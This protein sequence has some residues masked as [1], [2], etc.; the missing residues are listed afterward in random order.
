M[1]KHQR[2]RQ[3]SIPSGIRDN[4][5]RGTV[6]D[7][8]QTKIQ[9]GSKLSIVSAYFTIY[10]FEAL[11]GQ[12][13]AIDELQFLF[14]EPRF[15][16]SLDPKKTDRKAFK[17]EDEGLALSNRLQQQ[18]VARECADWIR[19]RVQIRSIKQVNLLHGKMYHIAPQGD[20]PDAIMGS[21]NFTVRGLGLGDSGNNIELNL[22]VQDKRDLSDLQVWFEEIWSDNTLVED[23]KEQVLHYLEQLYQN[24]SPEFIYYKTLFHIFEQ[25]LADQDLSGL[26]SEKKS[27]D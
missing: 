27:T 4:H 5:R 6:G 18:R 9:P 12:L 25:F 1:A 20:R 24:H 15:V 8:L 19:D 26:L 2:V 21:S 14:G 17:L 23:V 13:I 3:E 22:E 11:K 10:A 16:R 7:F